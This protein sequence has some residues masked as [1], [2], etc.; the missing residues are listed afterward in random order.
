M[1]TPNVL[2]LG[3]G[4]A[5]YAEKLMVYS[6]NKVNICLIDIPQ[7]LT[8]SYVYLCRIFGK[9]RVLLVSSKEQLIQRKPGQF[10]LIT[11]LL[12]PN[13]NYEF[14]LV[15]NMHSFSEMDLETIEYYLNMLTTNTSF[16]IE[17]NVNIDNVAAGHLEIKSSD[18]PIP[19]H[20]KLLTRFSDGI[21]SRHV[22]SIYMK[23]NSKL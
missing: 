19:K 9:D 21:Q 10:V 14:D 1:D 15:H 5:D 3:S 2:D 7:N 20:L 22:T 23:I 8:T 11:T 6:Q 17:T 13:L 18:F 12:I 16:L 4:Y